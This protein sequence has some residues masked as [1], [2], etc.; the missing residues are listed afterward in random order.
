MDRNKEVHQQQEDISVQSSFQVVMDRDKE[1]H[2]QQEDIA[3]LSTHPIDFVSD[4][5]FDGCLIASEVEISTTTEEKQVKTPEQIRPFPKALPRKN[6]SSGK[7][8]ATS[9]VLTDT[10]VKESLQRDLLERAEK[11]KPTAK[12]TL[13]TLKKQAIQEKRDAVHREKLQAQLQ[14]KESIRLKKE[15]AQHRKDLQQL[16][17]MNKNK[18]KRFSPQ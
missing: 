5:F 14:R 7:K 13:K 17:G 9:R 18:R 12:E 15:G 16:A 4:K 8:R 11:K 1:V 10:P 2:Q 6:N 3:S